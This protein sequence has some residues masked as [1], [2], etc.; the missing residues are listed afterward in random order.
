MFPPYDAA[1]HNHHKPEAQK[2]VG[3]I[4]KWTAGPCVTNLSL[5]VLVY[6]Q[7]LKGFFFAKMHY[8]IQR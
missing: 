7:Q 6:D 3:K 4:P 5:L 8:I 1:I 2:D